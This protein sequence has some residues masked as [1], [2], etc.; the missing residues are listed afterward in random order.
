MK[1][2]MGLR[3][4]ER[5]T[6]TQLCC[7]SRA[8]AHPPQINEQIVLYVLSRTLL[9]LLP[10]LYTSGPSPPRYPTQPLPHPLPPL[11]SAEANPR[12]IPPAQIPF[13]VVAAA[14]WAGVMYM[15]RHR[16]E[17][18]Q[19]GMGNSMRECRRT[20]ERASGAVLERSGVKDEEASR[21]DFL[22]GVLRREGADCRVLVSRL[23]GVDGSAHAALAQ[24]VIDLNPRKPCRQAA[25]AGC[26]GHRASRQ[27][28]SLRPH[29]LEGLPCTLHMSL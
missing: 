16:G 3:R 20:S 4:T 18:I 26:V 13:A 21:V 27:D 11:T 12:P 23:G 25:L 8:G 22:F 29:I 19:P 17:R 6:S 1:R 5:R 24:Q 7:I 9:S 2:S 14:S 15:F 10:R 28:A